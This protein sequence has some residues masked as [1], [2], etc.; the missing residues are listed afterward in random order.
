VALGCS[1]VC[2]FSFLLFSDIFIHSGLTDFIDSMDEKHYVTVELSKPMGIVFE[3][4]DATYGGIFVHS[5]KEGGAAEAAGTVAVGDQ[6]VG[7][8]AQK[9]AGQPFDDALGVILDA[10][11][12]TV[13]LIFFR[14]TAEQL[15]GPTGASQAWLDEFITGNKKQQQPASSETETAEAE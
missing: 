10:P 6:L 14:G 8:A 9:V 2:F 11:G 13:P 5:L 15:Y 4:N 1:F 12:T 7:V 3:E